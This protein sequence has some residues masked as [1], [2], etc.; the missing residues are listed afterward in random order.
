MQYDNH[1]VLR[2][3]C[4]NSNTF[5]S[6][7]PPAILRE[8]SVTAASFLSPHIHQHNQK[9]LEF[10]KVSNI[11]YRFTYRIEVTNLSGYGNLTVLKQSRI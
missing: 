9:Y 6:D 5:E 11:P 8:N 2:R 3:F 1:F 7:S 10:P 4:P